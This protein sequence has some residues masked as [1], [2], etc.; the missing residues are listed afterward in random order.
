MQSLSIPLYLLSPTQTTI[1]GFNSNGT[2][3]LGKIRL[4]CQIDNLK[5]K[6]TCYVV[7]AKTSYNLLLGRTW[8]HHNV[9]VPSTLHQVIK[10]ADEHGTV[11]TLLADQHPFKGVENYYTDYTDSLLYQEQLEDALKLELLDFG[12]EADSELDMKYDCP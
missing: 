1:F 11:R 5:I 7:D 6:V 9:I 8:I 4:K 10:Y 12:N 2:Q 3:P